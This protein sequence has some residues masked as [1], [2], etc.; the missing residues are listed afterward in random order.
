MRLVKCDIREILR[1]QLHVPEQSYSFLKEI[2][3]LRGKRIIPDSILNRLHFG[4]GKEAIS[5][6]IWH[7]IW[8]ETVYFASGLRIQISFHRDYEY[9]RRIN[10]M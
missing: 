7:H 4:R 3:I 10:Q 2:F 5:E 6:F 1:C 8:L 9:I